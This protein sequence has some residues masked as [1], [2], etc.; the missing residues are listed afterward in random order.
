[1][2]SNQIWIIGLHNSNSMSNNFYCP[3]CGL[4]LFHILKEVPTNGSI[5]NSCGFEF[6]YFGQ[7]YIGTDK[8]KAFYDGYRTFWI[9]SGMKWYFGD[10]DKY[11][12]NNWNPENQ[13]KN[14]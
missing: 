8:E 2:V 1:M 3:I 4:E 5:C 9:R 14:I 6:N 10:N 11:K 12:P 7:K 13:L